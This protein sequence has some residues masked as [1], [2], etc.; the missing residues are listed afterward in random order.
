V[1]DPSPGQWKKPSGL[2]Q[3]PSFCAPESIRNGASARQVQRMDAVTAVSGRARND[4]EEDAHPAAPTLHQMLQKMPGASSSPRP[5][6]NPPNMRRKQAAGRYAERGSCEARDASNVAGIAIDPVDS[7]LEN[8]IGTRSHRSGTR[9]GIS[10]AEASGQKRG[11]RKCPK[12]TRESFD[13]PKINVH[14]DVPHDYL[15]DDRLLKGSGRL[16]P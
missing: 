15:S 13:R 14:P 8:T 10:T 3:S 7:L 1:L 2:I 5:S 12:Y 4:A 6:I 16:H 11:I 9:S